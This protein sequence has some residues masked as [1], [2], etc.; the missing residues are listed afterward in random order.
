MSRF[1]LLPVEVQSLLLSACDQDLSQEQIA[2]LETASSH[3]AAARLLIDCI[4]LD[5]DLRRIAHGHRALEESFN[6]IGIAPPQSDPPS[7]AAPPPIIG[8]IDD[9]FR[10]THAYFSSG[11][12]VAYLAAT[13]ICVVGLLIGALVHVS[14]P[15]QYVSPRDSV[16]TRHAQS[17][18]PDPSS[19][20]ARI[21]GMVDCAWA[22]AGD[23]V[24][25]SGAAN[26]KSDIIN[27]E[28]VLHL[29]DRLALKS[30]L[31]EI[32]YDTGAK[33]ILQGPVTYVVESPDGGYLFLGKLTAKL[34]K[35]SD[36]GGQRSD[37]AN[38][39]SEIINQKFLVRTPTAL[40]TDLGTEFGVEVDK[41]GATLSR[42]FR[43]SVSVQAISSAGKAEGSAQVLRENQTVRVDC[44]GGRRIT[45]VST[46]EKSVDFVREFPRPA[47]NVLN[48]ADMM[49]GNDATR[50]HGVGINAA[51][52]QITD[53]LDQ[54]YLVGDGKY[55]RVAG[56]P[57]VDGVFIPDG[58]RDPVQIDS[59]RGTFSGFTPTENRTAGGIWV[60]RGPIRLRP[61][62]PWPDMP[63]KPSEEFA[64]KYEM[65]WL[66]SD[67]AHVDLDH[68]G[69]PDFH[70][71]GKATVNSGILTLT[72]EQLFSNGATTIWPGKFSVAGGYTIETRV[73]VESSSRIGPFAI[74]AAAPTAQGDFSAWLNVG[75]NEL[76]WGPTGA[77]AHFGCNTKNDYHVYRVAQRPGQD[78]YS[79]WRDGVLLRKDL[80]NGIDTGGLNRMGFGKAGE[81]WGGTALVDYVRFTPGAYAPPPASPATDA[82]V[83]SYFAA[84]STRLGVVDYASSGH[85]SLL[86]HASA[87]ITFDLE[88]IRRANPGQK[89]V[90]FRAVAGNVETVS[91][92]G[93]SVWADFRVVVDGRL[94]HRRREINAYNGALPVIIPLDPTDRFLT[95]AATDGGNG[96]RCDWILFGDPQLD[97]TPSGPEP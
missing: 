6:L 24:Q 65:D 2:E 9:T 85:S 3:E 73:K 95:I 83:N 60:G 87:G 21:T 40:V 58:R 78:V 94:R 27:H 48:L 53:G 88:A 52:G 30:G 15:N 31:L 49:L 33:V 38:Q 44:D 23:R 28:S 50:Q 81:I 92:R 75:D 62:A 12:P 37:S 46:S 14:Q 17:P 43:G 51:N 25:G 22:E 64:Y 68:N 74:L 86:L 84:A 66:P 35:K 90:R 63:V 56:V 4:Q 19:I 10:G 67:V 79:L 41:Q 93:E 32:A 76:T 18:L 54:E 39:K 77:L 80:P 61:P 34:E 82:F 7:S 89:L 13:V 70:P 69:K 59:A 96:I 16:P 5:A 45:A 91:A 42:V 26:Q 71:G 97:L 55:H 72:D 57:C 36:V 11:W 20:V 47:V 8:L 29:G 1:D